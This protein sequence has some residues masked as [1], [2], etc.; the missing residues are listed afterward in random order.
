MKVVKTCCYILEIIFEYQINFTLFQSVLELRSY[1]M[2]C[3]VHFI[4]ESTLDFFA[5]LAILDLH[6]FTQ[7]KKLKG[8]DFAESFNHERDKDLT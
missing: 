5:Y 2:Y 1:G 8:I 3:E 7:L 6:L 4:T